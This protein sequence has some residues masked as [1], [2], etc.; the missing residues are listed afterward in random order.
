MRD[1]GQGKRKSLSVVLMIA[2]P[3]PAVTD[4]LVNIAFQSGVDIVELGIPYN[5]PF[6]DS[7]VMNASMQRALAYSQDIDFYLEYLKH[8][9]ELHPDRPFEVMVYADTVKECGMQRFVDALHK[10]AMDAVLVAD[11]VRE[12]KEFL[13]EWDA[14]LCGTDVIPIRFVPHPYD[15]QQIL[16]ISAHARGF[17][18]SQTVAKADGSRADV[19]P[20]NEVKIRFLKKSGISVPI[21]AAYGLKT[22]EQVQK[23]ITMGADGVLIGTSVLEKAAVVSRAE[24]AGYLR[25]LRKA[26]SLLE[27]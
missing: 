3:Q 26:A 9:R 27:G 12:T 19:L 13:V 5:N 6:L 7:D 24:F 17:V 21:V 4:E 2:D 18:I 1:V 10:A 25:S 15:P 23:V 22:S 14:C 8:I 16:E 20:D 11:Y